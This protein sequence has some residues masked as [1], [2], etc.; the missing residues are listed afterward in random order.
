MFIMKQAVFIVGL[1]LLL[2]GG[3][4]L[5]AFA[6]AQ[7]FVLVNRTGVDLYGVYISPSDRDD[8]EE[9]VLHYVLEDGDSIRITFSNYREAYWD[10]MVKDRYGNSV[11]WRGL[12]LSRISRVI[13]H[14]NAGQIWAEYE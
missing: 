12:D 5:P 10:L 7:D 1:V 14:A 3:L 6:G 4:A 11:Y 2:I 13:L 9:N 8:W